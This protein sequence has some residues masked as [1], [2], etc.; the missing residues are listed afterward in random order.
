VRRRLLNLLTT[1]S[2][3]CVAALVV[4]FTGCGVGDVWI[5]EPGESAGIVFLALASG[6]VAFFSHAA[7]RR[8]HPPGICLRCGYDLR[9][10]PDR[11]PECGTTATRAA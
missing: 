5:V 10:T 8:C 4:M 11:C 2:L 6:A 7:A 1:A 3:L 9:A